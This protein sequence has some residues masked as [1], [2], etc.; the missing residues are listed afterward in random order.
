METTQTE[1]PAPTLTSAQIQRFDSEMA[2]VLSHYPADRKQAAMLPALRLM[3][4]MLGY[5]TPDSLRRVA[6]T[7]EVSPEK[8]A[9]VATFYTQFRLSPVGTHYIEVCTNLSCSL[10]GAEQLVEQI[11]ARL[12]IGLGEST[13]DGKF[14]LREV[15]CLASCGTAPCLQVN[16]EFYETLTPQS[17]DQLLAKLGSQPGASAR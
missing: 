3:Q 4:D 13:P 5:L 2:V 9:E 16:E 12:G 1:A 6:T 15:E 14:S 10:R 8:T 7:L 11:Q 17:L